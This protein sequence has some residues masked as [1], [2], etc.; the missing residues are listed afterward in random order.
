MCRRADIALSILRRFRYG[1]VVAAIVT[2][3][4]I[5]A[6]RIAKSSGKKSVPLLALARRFRRA[7]RP[8]SAISAPQSLRRITA[9]FATPL[10]RQFRT[11]QHRVRR[12][13]AQDHRFIGNHGFAIE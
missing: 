13:G 2:A 5:G 4:G 1:L 10:G 8:W 3:A 7:T 6:R 12:H 9:S 11:L